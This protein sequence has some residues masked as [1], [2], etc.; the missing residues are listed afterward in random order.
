MRPLVVIVAA[1]LATTVSVLA[2]TQTLSGC[3]HDAAPSLPSTPPPPAAPRV[4]PHPPPPPPPAGGN[5]PIPPSPPSPP[6]SPED[7]T[8]CACPTVRIVGSTSRANRTYALHGPS[9]D[10][11]PANAD[12]TRMTGNPLGGANVYVTRVGTSGTVDGVYYDQGRYRIRKSS[13]GRFLG[14]ASTTRI[15][16]ICVPT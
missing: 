1:A 4:P 16:R 7:P 15:S 12:A 6:S 3:T 10:P 2:A 14:T 5:A 13:T 11:Y 8:A 9:D